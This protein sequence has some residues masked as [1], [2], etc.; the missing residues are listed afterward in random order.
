MAARKNKV[1]LSETWKDR[2]SATMILNRLVSHVEGNLELSPTQIKAADIIL[3]KVVPDLARTEHVGDGGGPMEL[4]VSLIEKIAA[5][6][7]KDG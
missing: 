4:R 2:I 1:T 7:L 6:R 3:K 5:R